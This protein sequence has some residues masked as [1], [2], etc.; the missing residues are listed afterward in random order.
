MFE[1]TVLHNITLEVN[2]SVRRMLIYRE[3][4]NDVMMVWVYK[5]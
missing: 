3:G 5:G 4:A 2:T 1:C